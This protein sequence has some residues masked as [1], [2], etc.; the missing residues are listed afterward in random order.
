MA[1]LDQLREGFQRTWTSISEGWSRLTDAAGQAITRFTPGRHESGE[2]NRDLAR[3]NVGWGLLPVE[4]FDQGERIEVRLEAPGL[5]RDDIEV[6]VID[7]Q[8]RIAGEKRIEREHRDGDYHV[9]ECAYGRFARLIPLPAPV[10]ADS[11][12]ARYRN[13]VLDVTLEKSDGHR[14]RRIE[15]QSR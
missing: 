2:G 12:R 6:E 13:G 3:R 15:V 5:D 11:A 9:A 1:R 8:L 14:R 10:K 7:D 4:V